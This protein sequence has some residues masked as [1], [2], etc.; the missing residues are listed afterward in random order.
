MRLTLRN[1]LIGVVIGVVLGLLLA[2]VAKLVGIHGTG[3][4]LLIIVGV[5][6]TV[7]LITRL[8]IWERLDSEPAAGSDRP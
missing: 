3:T 6:V 5:G 7:P 8:P 1:I 2:L 4:A